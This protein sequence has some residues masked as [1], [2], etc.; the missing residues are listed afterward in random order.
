MSDRQ[1]IYTF[2]TIKQMASV[3]LIFLGV[4]VDLFLLVNGN[5]LFGSQF[6][7]YQH[8]LLYYLV[9]LGS[10][11]F[12]AG[13]TKQLNISIESAVIY[14][15]PTFI[16]TALLV[17][18]VVRSSMMLVANE[19]VMQLFLQIFVVSLSEEMIFRGVIINYI[20]V[21]PQGI[22]FG[23]F[24]TAAYYSIY[25]VNIYA[26]IMAMVMGTLWGYLVKMYPKNGIAITWGMH[27]GWNVALLIPIF[28]IKFL[29]GT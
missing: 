25:G 23:L 1:Y 19:V 26:M 7:A 13:K 9:M 18:D 17:G 3:P 2:P 27:A 14:F 4:M 29:L 6:N 22:L 28:S 10:V 12:F 16:I 21:I 15:V 11:F 8:V 20:G 24:H 5:I